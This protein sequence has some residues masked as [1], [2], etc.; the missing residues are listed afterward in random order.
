MPNSLL[1]FLESGTLSCFGQLVALNNDYRGFMLSHQAN[2]IY[3][4]NKRDNVSTI[5]FRFTVHTVCIT[6]EETI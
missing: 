2:T 1:L 6:T 3:I 4:L 5:R